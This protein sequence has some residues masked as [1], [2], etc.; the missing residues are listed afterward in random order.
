MWL[1]IGFWTPALK[2]FK[3]DVVFTGFMICAA[4]GSYISLI[5]TQNLE[6]SRTASSV[7]V[8]AAEPSIF[9]P[10]VNETDE[11]NE[12]SPSL[13]SLVES[14]AEEETTT[15]NQNQ[16]WTSARTLKSHDSESLST[17][18]DRVSFGIPLRGTVFL[19]QALSAV[20]LM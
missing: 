3:P 5:V 13:C 11:E 20:V 15:T 16:G 18:K 9:F 8:P 14:V 17:W 10:H 12:R 1:F 6:H 19:Y 4:L 7:A 2:D